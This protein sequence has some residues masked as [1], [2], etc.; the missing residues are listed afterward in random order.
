MK[1]S[2]CWACGKADSAKPRGAFVGE[3]N[4]RQ[5]WTIEVCDPCGNGEMLSPKGK[6]N[7]IRHI[8]KMLGV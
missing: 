8:G 3:G 6:E 7:V 1:K 2:T 4:H 5:F